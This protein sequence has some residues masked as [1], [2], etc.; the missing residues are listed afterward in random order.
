MS[1]YFTPEELKTKKFPFSK[2]AFA[3]GYDF[4][5]LTME[6]QELTKYYYTNI[7]DMREMDRKYNSASYYMNE[8]Q[9]VHVYLSLYDIGWGFY[10]SGD[11]HGVIVGCYQS[12]K[13]DSCEYILD[14]L[15]SEYCIRHIKFNP[16][17]N[18][19]ITDA[20]KEEFGIL[21]RNVLST[22]SGKWVQVSVNNNNYNGKRV[23]YVN[24][25]IFYSDE[26]MDIYK[27]MFDCMFGFPKAKNCYV[28]KNKYILSSRKK[29]KESL[30]YHGKY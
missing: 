25:L 13:K 8:G 30:V 20:I 24:K 15:I 28:P 3:D 21:N 18:S 22:L 4:S 17:N 26:A 16:I 9:F 1:N 2:Q 10:D 12:E 19:V 6:E 11:Y 7:D 29:R 23:S 5:S 14:V 27:K